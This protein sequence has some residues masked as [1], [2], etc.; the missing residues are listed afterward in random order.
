MTDCGRPSII[1]VCGPNGAGKSTL[2]P[3]LLHDTLAL[4]RYVNADAIAAGLGE[5]HSSS[6]AVALQA[7]M[8]MLRRIR[9]LIA[10]EES[11]AFETTLASRSFAPWLR[12]AREQRGYRVGLLFLALSTPEEAIR[13]VHGRVAEGGHDVPVEVIQRRFVRGL[14]NLFGLYM[15]LVDHWQ[16]LATDG[17]AIVTRIARHG[18]DNG[19]EIFDKERW[20][21]LETHHGTR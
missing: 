8:L 2:A 10:A 13:R 19:I 12:E 5:P 11:F 6:G 21:E 1:V 15:P 4:E 18:D 17:S 9:S 16:L 20:Q 3:G 14:K 7:G